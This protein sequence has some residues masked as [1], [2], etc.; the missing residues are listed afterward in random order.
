VSLSVQAKVREVAVI[1]IHYQGGALIG[2]S[3]AVRE[4]LPL[5]HPQE[6]N[7]SNGVPIACGNAMRKAP[8]RE[9]LFKDWISGSFSV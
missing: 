8:L 5:S 9:N 2:V 6:F 7:E 1:Q 3:G 4:A